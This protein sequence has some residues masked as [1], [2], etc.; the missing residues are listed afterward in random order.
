MDAKILTKILAH[1]IQ[2]Y[3]KRVI[4]HDH[5]GFIPGLQGCFKICKP[6]NVIPHINKRKHKNHEVLSTDAEKAFGKVQPPF[7]IKTLHGVG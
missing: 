3:F 4:Y 1:R 2:Q 6:I 7:W 5:V